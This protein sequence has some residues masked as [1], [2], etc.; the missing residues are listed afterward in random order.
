[1]VIKM[2]NYTTEDTFIWY[3]RMIYTF[4]TEERMR[5]MKHI[6]VYGYKFVVIFLELC[7]LATPTK[8]YITVQGFSPD[9]I[10]PII[11]KDIG[12]EAESMLLALNYFKNQQ[13]IEVWSEA[14]NTIIH[15][16]FLKDKIGKRTRESE[17]RQ[18][19]RLKAK[20]S[21]Q[22]LLTLKE[23]TKTI[24]EKCKTYG[25]FKNVFLTEEEYLKLKDRY[26]N[27][28]E[29]IKRVGIDKKRFGED[30]F[31]DTDFERCLKKGEE[32]GKV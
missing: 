1:M 12:E 26:I 21:E 25:L 27:A 29:I 11:C 6:P 10:A 3:Y 31:I 9:E 16:P 19:R 20:E 5:N 2:N 30:E 14:G 17:K 28:E 24:L 8:G 4:F 22:K 7:S 18:E 32:I 23:E 15:I 13:L